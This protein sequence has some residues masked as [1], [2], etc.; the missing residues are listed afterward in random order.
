MIAQTVAYILL[1]PQTPDQI[2]EEKRKAK[3][4]SGMFSADKKGNLR[5]MK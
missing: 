4:M 2:R 5:K 3:E 1:R